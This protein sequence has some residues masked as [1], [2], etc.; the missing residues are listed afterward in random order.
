[1]ACRIER[2]LPYNGAARPKASRG[3]K[4]HQASR[5]GQ[6]TP[7]E[8]DFI[9][10]GYPP[11]AT[12][13]PSMD[14]ATL[15]LAFMVSTGVVLVANVFLS[16]LIVRKLVTVADK[17]ENEVRRALLSRFDELEWS[18][19]SFQQD[20]SEKINAQ[21]KQ[22]GQ[23]AS[24]LSENARSKEVNFDRWIPL[25]TNADFLVPFF[26]FSRFEPI[27]DTTEKRIR[28]FIMSG[29]LEWLGRKGALEAHVAECGCYL[30][31]SAFII[32]TILKRHA[33]GHEF[34]I[35]D[36]FQGLSKPSEQDLQPLA[37]GAD[38]AEIASYVEDK[39]GK[40][41][42]HNEFE[43]V[44]A[45]LSE[46]DFVKF[47]RGWIPERF[48]DVEEQRFAFVN[49]DVDLYE[50]THESLAFFY[51]R[52]LEGGIINIDDYGLTTWPGCTRAVDEWLEINTP[53]LVIPIPGG[54]LF[55]M[56]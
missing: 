17:T 44:Q 46:F 54:G 37:A 9:G 34:H 24:V 4:K 3:A 25:A 1:M 5:S 18:T 55:L 22:I 33:F 23:L 38:A 16:R 41:P 8:T 50:P 30:G 14:S 26:A 42:F 27:K 21:G 52:L 19:R 40:R 7:G 51:P 56:K 29:A 15:L 53:S 48:H 31:H 2:L 39:L 10:V 13:V 28:S 43:R 20:L 36:S 11:K 12:P 32:A 47:H 6:L 45:N 35:F 49:I